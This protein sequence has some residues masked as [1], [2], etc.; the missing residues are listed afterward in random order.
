[1]R[2]VSS[3]YSWHLAHL[4]GEKK[5]FLTL[6]SVFRVTSRGNV[7]DT[8]FAFMPKAGFCTQESSIFVKYCYFKCHQY[9]RKNCEQIH[10]IENFRLSAEKCFEKQQR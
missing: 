2:K 6:F 7:Q 1:M 8:V 10:R 3:P 9:H 4:N 5:V